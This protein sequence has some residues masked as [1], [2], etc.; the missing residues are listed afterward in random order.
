MVLNHEHWVL[1][2][3]SS[4]H[5]QYLPPP[6]SLDDTDMSK[7]TLPSHARNRSQIAVAPQL[8]TVVEDST[9]VESL[10]ET[11][12]T[13]NRA[14]KPHTPMP[15]LTDPQGVDP[16]TSRHDIFPYRISTHAIICFC[17]S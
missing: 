13:Q 16:S 12:M 4:F 14:Q 3:V 6:S 15:R 5:C 7:R 2:S 11:Q 1:N 8:P 10:T 17:R 9:D